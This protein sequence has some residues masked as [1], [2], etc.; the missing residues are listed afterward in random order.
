MCRSI[1]IDGVFYCLPF[2][3]KRQL[4]IYDLKLNKELTFDSI[5]CIAAILMSK[6][7]RFRNHL[8][9]FLSFLFRCS[10]QFFSLHFFCISYVNDVKAIIFLH[11]TLSNIDT[12]CKCPQSYNRC[13]VV[14]KNCI[15]LLVFVCL[16]HYFHWF[17]CSV[18]RWADLKMNA[19]KLN[20]ISFADPV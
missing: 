14:E 16:L 2:R 18:N 4:Y 1:A 19:I 20:C 9:F 10:V 6:S 8:D 12:Y 15:H 17:K 11:D 13:F 5:R 7:N 3:C